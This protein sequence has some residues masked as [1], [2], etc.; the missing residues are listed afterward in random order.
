MTVTVETE[1]VAPQSSWSVRPA[2][3]APDQPPKADDQEPFKWKLTV[4]PA[5]GA[6]QLVE[7][8]LLTSPS[9]QTA[10]WAP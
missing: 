5:P 1:Y 2:S 6:K 3:P 4:V 10:K 9:G 8:V 7:E